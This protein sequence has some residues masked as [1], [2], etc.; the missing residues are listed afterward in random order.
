MAR[1]TLTQQIASEISRQIAD[2][3]LKTGDRLPSLRRYMAQH[4]VSKNTVITAYE[5]LASQGLV[6]SRHGKG[7]FV[8]ANSPAATDD[9]DL[10]P[11]NRALDRIWMMRQ[12]FVRDPGHSHLGEGFPPVDWL[13]DMRLDKYHRQVVRTSGLTLYR[14]GSR[15][16]N[17][18]L[19]QRVALRLSDHAI[20][21]APREVV[22][23][24]GANHAMDIIIRRYLNHGE[25]VLVDDPGYY[26]LFGKLQMHGARM[27]GVPRM[28]DGPDLEALENLVRLHR[29]KLFFVQTSAHNPTGSDIS[30]AKAHQLLRIAEKYRLLVV[31]DDAMAD[32]KPASTVRLSA[33]DG[34][35]N[36]LYIG[37]FSKSISAALRV[38]FI[39][40]NQGRIEELAD[41]KML[42]HTT[43]SEY[44]ERVY[45]A[46]LKDDEFKLHTMRLQERVRNATRRGL[47][48]LDRLGAEVFCRPQQSLYLWARFPPIADANLLTQHCLKHGVV[49]APGAIFFVDRLAPRPWTRLNV[50]YLADPAFERSVR[51]LS[52]SSQAG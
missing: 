36:T 42:V 48:I 5:M 2:G 8:R 31:E 32:F 46:I 9:D 45:D 35:R 51:D 4:G 37:S 47:E 49:L 15:L 7:F 22:T 6:E 34:L 27:L 1:D 41:I 17:I 10:Q 28:A 3:I 21:C 29:P 23:T 14:Y 38:G 12:Q 11:Y 25:P 13:A 39:A 33:L 20:H 30:P 43:G 40:G 19:R 52:A 44:S 24:F 50:A 26:P 18:G 16:G